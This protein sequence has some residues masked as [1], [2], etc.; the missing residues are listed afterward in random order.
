L[1]K[2]K[3]VEKEFFQK[4]SSFIYEGTW[5]SEDYVDDNL[6]YYDALS[7]SST[8]ARPK[9]QYNISVIRLSALEEFKSKVFLLGDVAYIQDNSFFGYDTN[10]N[11]IKEKVLVT[12]ITSNFDSPEKDSFKI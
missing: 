8:S 3:E 6:F 7:V 11:P 5:T 10:G 2:N 4:Y 12:E 1:E 9:V